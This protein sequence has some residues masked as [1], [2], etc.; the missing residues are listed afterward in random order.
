MSPPSDDHDCGWRSYAVAL[1]GDVEKLKA[2][3]DALKRQVFGKKSEKMPPMER[4]LRRGKK[5]DPA[6]TLRKRKETALA[7]EKLVT[8]QVTLPVPESQRSCPHCQRSD[9]RPVGEGKVT[10]VYDYVPGY[11]RRQRIARETLACRCG[12]YII[13]APGPDK[14]TDKTQYGPGFVAHLITQKCSQSTPFHRLE[15]EYRWTGIPIARSTM[16]DLFHRHA[17]L[18]SPLVRRLL[19]RIAAS[20][21]VLADETSVRMLGT[22]KKAYLWTFIA[23]N[24]IGYVFSPDRSGDTPAR[25]LGGSQ[26]TLVVDAYTGYNRVTDTGGRTRA[27]CLAHARRKFFDAFAGDT[28]D[29]EAKTALE[30]IHD[31]YVVEHEAKE[32]QIVGTDEHLELRRTRSRPLLAKLF[33]W[34][35]QERGRHLPKGKMGRAISYLLN[36]RRALTRFTTNVRVPVDN[37]RSESALRVVALGRKNFLFVG[38]EDAGDNIAGLYSLVATCIAHGKNPVEYL[39]DVLV[40]INSCPQNQ[41]DELL[42]HRWQAAPD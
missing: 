9:L 32:R 34:A 5:A 15:K 33:W 6:E 27:G 12:Q 26:G 31:I 4:V 40:R 2:E 41:L 7:K 42:P 20:D 29:P 38:N 3:L 13:T 19:A 37:N 25:I 1:Q 39:T 28:G 35:R 10:T 18:L 17:E 23:G 16:T 30:L 8:E 21:V 11:F 22:T 24:D 36:N 14:A